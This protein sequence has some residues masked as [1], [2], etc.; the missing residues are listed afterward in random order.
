MRGY[1]R[2]HRWKERRHV[3]GGTG[4][5]HWGNRGG[6]GKDREDGEDGEDGE[7]KEAGNA[8]RGRRHRRGAGGGGR[9]VHG[10]CNVEDQNMCR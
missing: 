5:E 7:G 10:Q 4:E 2:G 1:R 8:M 6:G 3:R 9:A